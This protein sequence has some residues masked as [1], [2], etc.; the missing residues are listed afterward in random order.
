M[1]AD[2]TGDGLHH[3]SEYTD[4]IDNPLAVEE[5]AKRLGIDVELEAT[6]DEAEAAN[7]TGA[8]EGGARASGAG[9]LTKRCAQATRWR[10]GSTCASW[11]RRS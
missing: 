3:L 2:P 6:D 9:D 10:R 8:L 7:P 1:S 4:G 5:E 11:A